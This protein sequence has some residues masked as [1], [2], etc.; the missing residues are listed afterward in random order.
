M[1]LKETDLFDIFEHNNGWENTYL[2]SIHSLLINLMFFQYQ[3][4]STLYFWS[5]VF[6]ER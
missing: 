2:V 1:Q 6:G 5:L 4:K 3:T